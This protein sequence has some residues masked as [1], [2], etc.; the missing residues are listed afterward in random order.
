MHI[1]SSSRYEAQAMYYARYYRK[2]HSKILLLQ[3]ECKG[4]AQSE[5]GAPTIEFVLGLRLSLQRDNC[6]TIRRTTLQ[7]RLYPV[8]R[9]VDLAKYSRM[10]EYIIPQKGRSIC[11]S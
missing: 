10:N 6:Y 5:Y 8:L 3:Q 2:Q 11:P 9:K 7:M 4:R 1:L